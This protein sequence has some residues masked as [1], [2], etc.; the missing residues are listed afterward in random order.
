MTPPSFESWMFLTVSVDKIKLSMVLTW[1]Q[2][3]EKDLF[4]LTE[5]GQK[6]DQQFF[7]VLSMCQKHVWTQHCHLGDPEH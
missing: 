4:S 2:K 5:N 6:F 1:C 7:A 3:P